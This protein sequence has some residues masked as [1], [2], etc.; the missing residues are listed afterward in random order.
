MSNSIEMMEPEEFISFMYEE[1]GVYE[2]AAS[3]IWAKYWDT[4]PHTRF[5]VDDWVSF[6]FA[7]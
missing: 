5:A 2:L 3:A 4:H 7:E 6:F 1:Y